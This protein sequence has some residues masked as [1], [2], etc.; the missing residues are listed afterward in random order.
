MECLGRDRAE[1]GD[2]LLCTVWMGM[3]CCSYSCPERPL[4]PPA[5]AFAEVLTLPSCMCRCTNASSRSGVLP[6]STTAP[7][8]DAFAS[9]STWWMRPG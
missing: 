2:S 1:L 5:V 7:T 3:G 6:S 9:L 8:A 4:Q